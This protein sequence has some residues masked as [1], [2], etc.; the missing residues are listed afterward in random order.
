MN[1]TN[2]YKEYDSVPEMLAGIL[3]DYG[4]EDL[5]TTLELRKEAGLCAQCTK[6]ANDCAEHGRLGRLFN[7]GNY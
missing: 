1:V 7:W 2:T 6:Q 5:I 4:E 3:R